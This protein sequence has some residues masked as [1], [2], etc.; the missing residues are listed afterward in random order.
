M[1]MAKAFSRN[2]FLTVD[3]ILFLFAT[4]FTLESKSLFCSTVA[5]VNQYDFR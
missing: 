5:P 2:V 4:E 1:Q 3:F